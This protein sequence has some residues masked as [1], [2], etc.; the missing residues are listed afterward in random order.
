MALRI[1]NAVHSTHVNTHL[2]LKRIAAENTNTVYN[3]KKI[4]AVTWRHRKING[5]LQLF[6]N[7]KLIHTGKPDTEEARVHIRRFVRILQKQNHPVSLSP[8]RLVCMSATCKLSGKINLHDVAKYT[9]AT[10]EPELFNAAILKRGGLSLC[11][12]HTGT[13]VITGIRRLDTVYPILLELELLC[14]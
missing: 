1:T 11:V 14:S 6:P 4:T 9:N 3:P 2:D 7:G 10:Y 12:F 8:I 13:V 5:T